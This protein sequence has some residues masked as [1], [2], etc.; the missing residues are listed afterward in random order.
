MRFIR[1]IFAIQA[2]KTK[3]YSKAFKKQSIG[4][5]I[6]PPFKKSPSP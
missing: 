4:Q 1:I 6:C 5:L 2:K 3:K